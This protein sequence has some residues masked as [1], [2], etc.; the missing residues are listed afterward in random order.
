M[1]QLDYYKVE[2]CATGHIYARKASRKEYLSPLNYEIWDAYKRA[3]HDDHKQTCVMVGMVT[4]V[5]G[6][7]SKRGIEIPQ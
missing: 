6:W 5:P 2:Q 7:L 4:A 1:M 3:G